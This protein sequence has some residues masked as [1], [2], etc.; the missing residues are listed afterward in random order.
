MSVIVTADIQP[1]WAGMGTNLQRA[2]P[3]DAGDIT[4]ESLESKK[5]PANKNYNVIEAILQWYFGSF[6]CG[7]ATVSQVST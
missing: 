4:S 1:D 5:E 6:R 2:G 3:A 7:I